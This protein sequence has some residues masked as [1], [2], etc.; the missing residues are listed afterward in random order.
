MQDNGAFHNM[1]CKLS[2]AMRFVSCE[3]HEFNGV[4]CSHLGNVSSYIAHGLDCYIEFACYCLQDA[5]TNVTE[6]REIREILTSLYSLGPYLYPM[7]IEFSILVGKL[8]NSYF[9]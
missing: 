2:D 8:Y 6:I 3:R 5:P 4:D 9:F 7:E 1:V